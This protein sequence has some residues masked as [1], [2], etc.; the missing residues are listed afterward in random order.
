MKEFP[1][2]MDIKT[3][4][5]YLNIHIVTIYRLILSNKIKAVK[6]YGNYR[7]RKSEVDQWFK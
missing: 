6:F 2:I 7:F 3:L 1:E 4:S 5:K